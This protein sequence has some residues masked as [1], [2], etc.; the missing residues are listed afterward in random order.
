MHLRSL[1][2]GPAIDVWS[3]GC[4]VVEMLTGNPPFADIKES[5]AVLFHIANLTDAPLPL[6]GLSDEARAFVHACLQPNPARRP[7]ALTL[8]DHP[9][10]QDREVPLPEIIDIPAD[11]ARAVPPL[12]DVSD[13]QPLSLPPSQVDIVR[14][15]FGMKQAKEIKFTYLFALFKS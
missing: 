8:L 9:F 14:N 1:F 3:I 4:T 6:P 5:V 15:D 10:L 13:L 2:A 11:P 7:S 12:I